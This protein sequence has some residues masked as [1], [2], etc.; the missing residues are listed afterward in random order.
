MLNGFY[1]ISKKYKGIKVLWTICVYNRDEQTFSKSN[2]ESILGSVTT[3]QLCYF[4]AKAGIENNV[5]EMTW[6][7]ANKTL[8][9]KTGK[10]LDLAHE[11]QFLIHWCVSLCN[12]Q[13]SCKQ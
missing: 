4:R 11:L 1:A 7:C 3:A 13:I 9:T 10:R 5:N 6:P 12:P 8:F 2:I